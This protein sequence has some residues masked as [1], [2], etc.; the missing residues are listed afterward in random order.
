MILRWEMVLYHAFRANTTVC[1]SAV[2]F[3]THETAL[4]T[5]LLLNKHV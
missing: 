4:G 1:R 5:E 2:A 3:P